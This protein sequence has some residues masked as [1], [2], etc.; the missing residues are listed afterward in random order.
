MYMALPSGVGAFSRL[1]ADA[2]HSGQVPPTMG[3][4]IFATYRLGRVLNRVPAGPFSAK[5]IESSRE[6]ILAPVPLGD[7]SML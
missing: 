2:R 6:G 1:N 4:L 5:E 3:W 7:A